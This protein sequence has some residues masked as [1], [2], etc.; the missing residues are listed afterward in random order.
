FDGKNGKLFYPY[1][2]TKRKDGRIIPVMIEKHDNF[3][4][5]HKVFVTRKLVAERKTTRTP[6]RSTGMGREDEIS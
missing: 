1:V 4:R 3:E 2:M 6:L 5:I